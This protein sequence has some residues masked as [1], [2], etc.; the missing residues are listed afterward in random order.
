MKNLLVFR[1]H[2]EYDISLPMSPL[3]FSTLFTRPDLCRCEIFPQKI[4]NSTNRQTDT[5]DRQKKKQQKPINHHQAIYSTPS[6]FIE[7]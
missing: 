7:V 4:Q 6:N 2:Q 1:Y 5:T 3:E